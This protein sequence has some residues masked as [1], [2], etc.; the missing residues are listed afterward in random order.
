V[1][2]EIDAGHPVTEIVARWQDE[3]TGYDELRRQFLLY[4]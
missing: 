1:R 4:S 2:E 3:L